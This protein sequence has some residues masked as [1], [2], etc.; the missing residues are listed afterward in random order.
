MK[1][2]QDEPIVGFAVLTGLFLSSLVTKVML[3]VLG[4]VVV[5]EMWP[6]ID[7]FDAFPNSLYLARK[8]LGLSDQF[9]SFVPCPKCYKLYQN[10]KVTNFQQ[11]GN[12]T[13]MNCQYIEFSNS[14]LRKS[15]LCNTPLSQIILAKQPI[16]RPNLIYPFS[17]INQQ[18]ASMFL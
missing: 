9:H 16:I 10:Q 15:R 5:A 11:E 2:P 6:P 1:S 7:D 17:G 13:I 8:M 14:S 4:E 12:P 3:R 18:L